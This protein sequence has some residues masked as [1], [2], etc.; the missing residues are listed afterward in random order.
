MSQGAGRILIVEDD[1]MVCEMIC[2]VVEGLGYIV[3]GRAAEGE[4]A[5]S[6]VSQL[7][8]DLVLMDLRLPGIDGVEA[9]ARINAVCPT[10]VVVL[11]AYDTPDF[12]SRAIDAGVGAYLLKPPE[13]DELARA[14]KIAQARFADL[15]ELRRLAVSLREEAD[16]HARAELRVKQSEARLRSLFS[17]VPDLIINIDVNG[18][19]GEC[20]YLGSDH[21]LGLGS[22]SIGR[23][24]EEALPAQLASALKDCSERLRE[25]EVTR[26]ELGYETQDLKGTRWIEPRVAM[27]HGGE[28]ICVIINV[29]T[30]VE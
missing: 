26:F 11:T 30:L 16:A 23:P 17:A 3:A 12:V 18:V 15:E 19:I 25:G 4:E 2:S 5:V 20:N 9:T 7:R 21:A 6:L 10:P 27:L 29:P 8:P 28:L 14:M 22:E 24:I 1:A 13:A